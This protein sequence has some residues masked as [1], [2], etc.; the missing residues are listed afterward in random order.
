VPSDKENEPFAKVIYKKYFRSIAGFFIIENTV[1][2]T[3]PQLI[4]PNF[5][6]KLWKQSLATITNVLKDK[7]KK[8]DDPTTLSELKRFLLI[9]CRTMKS[10]GYSIDS[11]HDFVR[12]ALRERYLIVATAVI[13]NL[14]KRVSQ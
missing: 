3:A 11:F 8:S 1:A 12:A 5:K 9:F 7:I 14:F 13:N 10:Y 4:S 6:E 2:Q